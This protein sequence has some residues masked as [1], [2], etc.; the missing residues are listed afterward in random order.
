MLLATAATCLQVPSLSS[1]AFVSCGIGPSGEGLCRVWR[2]YFRAG[3][4]VG[5]CAEPGGAVLKFQDVLDKA[6]ECVPGDPL[7]GLLA[8]PDPAQ[9]PRE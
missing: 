8:A 9:H 5:S 4:R 1:T 7:A 6:Q 3:G 2:D